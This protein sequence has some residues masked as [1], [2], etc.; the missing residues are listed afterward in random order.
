MDRCVHRSA[1]MRIRFLLTSG[2]TFL[3]LGGQPALAQPVAIGVE[4][5]IR[6]T[7][8]VSG[9][10]MPESKRYI[11]G[12]KL[13]VRLPWHLSVEVDALYRRVGFLGYINSCCANSVTGER[14]NSWEF[15]MI[16][17]C[18]FP[19]GPKLHPFAG[20]GYAP[21]IVS[22]NDISSGSYLSNFDTGAITYYSNVHRSVSYP[23]TQ[24]LVV[25]GGVEFGARHVLISPELRYVHWSQ[26]FLNSEGGDGSFRYASSQ[27]ELFVLVGIA[28]H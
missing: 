5:G 27:D 10:L 19:S 6:T 16:V 23:V 13:E 3:F 18:R 11:V 26:P 7:G 8:D 14:D 20:V 21:R 17:K 1:G 15:P 24:G 2:F 25:S 12:P 22:G 9:T 28:W 4:G